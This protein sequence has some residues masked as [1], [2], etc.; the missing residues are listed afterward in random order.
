MKNATSRARTRLVLEE[1]ER[2]AATE[3]QRDITE[4]LQNAVSIAAKMS[5]VR[6]NYC[7]TSEPD[8][9]VFLGRVSCRYTATT[10]RR[11]FTAVRTSKSYSTRI[12]R[13]WTTEHYFASAKK[14]I[15][16]VQ[17][18]LMVNVFVKL[19]IRFQ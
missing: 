18:S 5:S 2:T 1:R 16:Q 4:Y 14:F 3:T 10:F 8:D 7:V 13:G 17:F 12:K 9:V 19:V 6:C 15:L 11:H